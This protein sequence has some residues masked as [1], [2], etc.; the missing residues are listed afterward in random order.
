MVQIKLPDGSLKECP[1]GVRPREVAEGIGRRLAEAAVAAVADGAIVDLDRP[2]ET[3]TTTENANGNE[4]GNGNGPTI[5]LRILT[6]RDREALD[7]LRHSTAH[8][9]ARAILRIFPGA[10]LAFGPTTQN[11]FYY[12]LDLPDR[13]LSE[14]DFPAIEAE[15][16]T[17]IRDAEPFERFALPVDEARQFVEDLGQT[18]KVEHIDDELHKFGILSFYRQGEFVDLCRGPHIPHAGKVGAFKLLTIAGAYWK[19]HTDRAMLQR[20]YG[21]AFFDKKD[22]DAYLAQVEEAKKR[23]HRKLGKE[24]GLFTISPLVGSGLIL[25]MP[26]G[27]I[28]RGVLENFLKD[29]LFRRGYLPVYTPHIGKIELYQTSGHYPYYKDSQF[30]PLRLLD[31][32]AMALV[33]GL[34]NGS[35]DDLAQKVLLGEAGIPETM[36]VAVGQVET[37]WGLDTVGRIKY[38]Q[39]YGVSEEY[40]LKPMNC[41]HHIQIY[42]A[43]PRSYRDLP[44]RLAEFGT[45]YRYEQSGELSGLTRVRGFTQDDAHLFCTVEQVRG[46]FRA[47]ME[48]TQFVL[49]TLGLT[50]YRLRLSKHDPDDPK[51]AGAA[52]DTWRR[53]EEDIRTV[54]DQM[55]LPYDEAPGEAAFYGPK[56]DFVVRDCIGRQWQLGTVQLDYV[57]PERF[58]LEYTGPDNQPH[59]PVMIHRAPFG[60]MERFMGILIEH[61]AGA[62]PL[63]LAPEQIRVLPISDKFADYG[64]HVLG[65]LQGGGLR[66]SIDLR[67]EKIGAKIRDAQL[68]KI[69]VMLVVGGKEAENQTVSYRDRIDGDRGAMPLDQAVAQLKAESEAR[70][71]R[72]VAQPT[73]VTTVDG[74]GEQHAY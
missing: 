3:K 71:I 17:L 55:G 46:E 23:D 26:K 36:P 69:P 72:Q 38:V 50:D 1:D 40:L 61:F 41:P 56:A 15:M 65:T 51:Y 47:T 54:L 44:V 12:D 11:G 34:E 60:S 2:L 45:V 31:D 66:A 49:N 35:V 53:A 48:L 24:L 14:T 21:T 5:E 58:G 63:W 22:L 57:L 25:W 8:I 20:V 70:S 67:P 43:Q 68:E 64:R 42:A 32:A 19:G 7:V 13:P 62:F 27:A 73:T 29:E 59:R 52:G 10:R 37:Y 4:G 9:M 39:Q 30:P 74:H 16:A 6:P 28:I 33:G 18:F